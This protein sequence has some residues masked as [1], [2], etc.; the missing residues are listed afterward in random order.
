MKINKIPNWKI[1]T[2]YK[3]PKIDKIIKLSKSFLRYVNKISNFIIDNLSIQ[4]HFSELN[5][6]KNY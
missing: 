6:F 4:Q 3:I 1:L 5:F 2:I